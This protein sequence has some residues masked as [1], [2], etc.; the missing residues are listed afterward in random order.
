MFSGQQKGEMIFKD[1]TFFVSPPSTR[2]V[3]HMGFAVFGKTYILEGNQ[4]TCKLWTTNYGIK[5]ISLIGLNWQLSMIM[6]E[7]T[8]MVLRLW[9]TT[10]GNHRR[11]K[12]TLRMCNVTLLSHKRVD[13]ALQFQSTVEK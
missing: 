5:K 13:L 12:P 2:E 10:Q 4:R 8:G 1:N 9:N 7:L 3:S 11:P 6:P